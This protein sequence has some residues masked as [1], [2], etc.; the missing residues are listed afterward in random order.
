[1]KTDVKVE[2]VNKSESAS[3]RWRRAYLRLHDRSSVTVHTSGCKA[4]AVLPCISQ[5]SVPLQL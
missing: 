5:A 3:F 4:A 1:M 2:T